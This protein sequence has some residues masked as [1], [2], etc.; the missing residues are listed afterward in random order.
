MSLEQII[1]YCVLGFIIGILLPHIALFILDKIRNRNIL[2]E[3]I[4]AIRREIE[5]PH[6]TSATYIVISPETIARLAKYTIIYNIPETE[7]K[8][9]MQAGFIQKAGRGYIVNTPV[10]AD[11]VSQLKS[12]EIGNVEIDEE[13]GKYLLSRFGIANLV[14]YKIDRK[15]GLTCIYSIG[16]T[17]LTDKI[18]K[19]PAFAHNLFMIGTKTTLSVDGMDLV[20]IPEG[21]YFFII[22][23]L[24]SANPD[25]I[26]NAFSR[27][28]PPENTEQIRDLLLS[29]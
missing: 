22:E 21:Q 17:K 1:L 2:K 25:N 11:Y 20:V 27:V 12:I 3:R 14:I 4:K 15:I 13:V 16:R 18:S 19:D 23:I 9:L 8:A 28:K 7:A 10:V 6:P 29:L 5:T 24:P 26:I